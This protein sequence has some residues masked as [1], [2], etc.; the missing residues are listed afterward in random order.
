VLVLKRKLGFAS[1]ELP[2]EMTITERQGRWFNAAG[3][4]IADRPALLACYH[5]PDA[6]PEPRFGRIAGHTNPPRPLTSNWPKPHQANGG[7]SNLWR[8]ESRD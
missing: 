2:T 7:K 5:N 3:R 6:R 8:F 4:E 1:T